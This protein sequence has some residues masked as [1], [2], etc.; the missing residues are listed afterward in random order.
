MELLINHPSKIASGIKMNA[1]D[2]GKQTVESPSTIAAKAIIPPT[3]PPH[4]RIPANV[5]P[6]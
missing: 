6:G 2:I 3:I 4:R 1:I 5:S